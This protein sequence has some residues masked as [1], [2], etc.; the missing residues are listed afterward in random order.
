MNKACLKRIGL[1]SGVLCATMALSGCPLDVVFFPDAGLDEA[2]R[3]ALDKSFGF[4]TASELAMLPS[5]E[6]TDRQISNL[7][8]LQFCTALTDLNLSNNAIQSIGQLTNLSNLVTL[9]LENNLLRNIEPIAGLLEL[10]SLNLSGPDQLI[11][12][13]QHLVANVTASG[14]ALGDG[15]TVVL[16]ANTTFGSDGLPLESFEPH[17]IEMESVNVTL[18]VVETTGSI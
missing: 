18:I 12:N 14:S 11:W 2:V 1:V 3:E 7:E 15:G 9:D 10:Q 16:P 5:L 13:W 8:G 17:L 4:I 6:A